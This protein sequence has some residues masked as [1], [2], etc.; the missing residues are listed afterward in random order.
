ML[1]I[2]AGDWALEADMGKKRKL[3]YAGVGGAM[4]AKAEEA[5]KHQKKPGPHGETDGKSTGAT[6]TP[7]ATTKEPQ[8]PAQPDRT[9]GPVSTIIGYEHAKEHKTRV[10][11]GRADQ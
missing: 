9:T 10:L 6:P 4:L 11:S 7:P 3:P 1:K 2:D 5:L 8:R